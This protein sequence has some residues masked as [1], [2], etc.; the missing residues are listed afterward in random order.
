MRINKN[1][2][3][4]LINLNIKKLSNYEIDS[5]ANLSQIDRYN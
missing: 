2:V 5:L 4:T 3:N 1:K